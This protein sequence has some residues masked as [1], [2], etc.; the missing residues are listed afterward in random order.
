MDRLDYRIRRGRQEAVHEVRAGIG[1]DFVP[2]SPLN[3]VQIPRKANSGRSSFKANQTTSFLV[4][5]FGS[6]AYSAKLLA[7]TGHRLPGFSQPHQ[8][9]DDVLRILVTGGSPLR[10]GVG[11]PQRIV[12]SSRSA[13]T[14]RTTGAGIWPDR[15]HCDESLT[16]V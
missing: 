1:F 9:D 2:W 11:I 15:F 4:S 8:C 10:G 14:L 3:S 6:G 5:G 16:N 7:G 12:V 13:P